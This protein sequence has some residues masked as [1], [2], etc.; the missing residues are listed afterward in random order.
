MICTVIFS[1]KNHEDVNRA[2]L[3]VSSLSGA[4]ILVGLERPQVGQ[5]SNVISISPDFQTTKLG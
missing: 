2:R 5:E 3:L 1:W 4:S